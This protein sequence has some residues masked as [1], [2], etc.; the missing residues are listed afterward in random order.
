MPVVE[1]ISGGYPERGLTETI[2]G[3]S[4]NTPIDILGQMVEYNL[5]LQEP[6]TSKEAND[7]RA[8]HGQVP[9]CS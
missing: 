9:V 1:L 8:S 5:P 7:Y 2:P 6:L 3:H 4:I